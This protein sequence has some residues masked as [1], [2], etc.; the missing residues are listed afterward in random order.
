MAV[1]ACACPQSPE[2]TCA[3]GKKLLWWSCPSPRVP[4]NGALPLWQAQASSEWPSVATLQL[5]QAVSMQ[6]TLVLSLG[7]TTET[8][9]SA[10]SP[11]PHQQMSGL[12]LQS[13]GGVV[14][15]F[16]AGHSPFCPLHIG[17]CA[18]LWGSKAPLHLDRSPRQ[19]GAF[20]GWRNLSSFT[21]PSLRHRC[22]PGFFF[23]FPF[24]FCPTWVRGGFLAL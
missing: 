14:L 1:V 22:P 2:S 20:P 11:C 15:T 4:N 18:L 16:C 8:W 3:Q 10:P 23:F 24:F 6:P 13:A 9:I 21:A 5:L 12:R 19:W 17:C 7:L